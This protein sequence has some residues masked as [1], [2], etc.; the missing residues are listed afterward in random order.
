M[1]AP[2]TSTSEPTL[3]RAFQSATAWLAITR[4]HILTIVYFATLTYGWIFTE[5]HDLLLPLIAVWD[6]FI[7]NF[8]NKAT[9]LDED[10]ANGIPGAAEAQA[11]KRTIE[12]ISFV[13]IALGLAAGFALYPEILPFRVAFTLIGLGYNYDI[14][15]GLVRGPDGARRFGLTR[16]KEMYF[17]K[18]FGSSMLFT[19]SVF[20]YPFFGL[21]AVG[22]Y[23]VEKL[24]LAIAFFIPL[25]LTYEI[26]YDLRDLDGDRALRV[27]TYPV[28]HGPDRAKQIIYA[29]IAFS[30][31]F[32]IAGAVGGVLRLREWC[33]VAGCLQ[34]IVLMRIF[35][36]GTRRP[37]QR[38][39]VI[40]TLIGAAQLASYNVWIWAGLPLGA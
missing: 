4:P 2:T 13:M 17:F 19:L 29:L 3:P 1:T 27:P 28:V 16:F 30:A 20:L 11:H 33:V 7:V 21:G 36:G 40:I 23:P 34:Q 10:L 6:W 38:E 39:T 9:D 22:D 25:E 12:L 26:I 32:P 14:V 18:N 31:L 37:T 35:C 8:N 15:P 24:L 5:R